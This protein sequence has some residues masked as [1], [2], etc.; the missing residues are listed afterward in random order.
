MFPR[1][2]KTALDMFP[3]TKG[4]QN[5]IK[6]Y[7]LSSRS[8]WRRSVCCQEKI[9]KSQK[10]AYFR[11]FCEVSIIR[12]ALEKARFSCMETY[13]LVSL[14][15]EKVDERKNAVGFRLWIRCHMLWHWDCC[16]RRPQFRLLDTKR[17]TWQ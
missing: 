6:M 17:Q 10:V 12:G 14:T 7:F 3:Q 1:T 9:N 11:T 2:Q 8:M 15:E 4:Q 16:Q 13:L 5:A